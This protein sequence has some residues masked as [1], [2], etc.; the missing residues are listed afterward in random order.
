M[1]KETPYDLLKED[2]KK[3][4]GKNN[5]ATM[6]LYNAL[7]RK[8]YERVSMCKT[9][10]EVWHTL[11]ITHQAKVTAIEEAKDL[12]TLPLDELVRNL[13]LSKLKLREQTSDD[14][15][16][17]RGS[18]EDLDEE[19]AD[20]FNLVARNFC[21]LFRKSNRFGRGNRFGN[22]ANRFGRSRRNSFRNKG[23][24]SSRQKGVCYNCNIK[25]HYASE[26]T[27]PNKNKA[28]VE[29]SWSGSEDGDEPQNDATCLIAI[30][31][32]EGNVVGRG[33][34]SH[35][36]IT[37][38]SVEHASGLTFNLISVGQLYDDDCVVNFTK[39][40]CT[41]INNGKTLVKG[42]RRNGLYTCK[43]GDNSKQQICLASIVDISTL[44]HRRLGYA[45]M[46]LVQNLD[47]NKLVRNLPKLSFKRHFCN[48]CGLRSQGY[49]QTSKAY[50]VLNK[51]TMRIEE[52]L[53]V[54]F[55]ESLPKP[56]SSPLVK[57]DRIIEPIVQNLVRSLPLEA[58]TS[59]S[60]YPKSVK[61]A[62]GYLIEQLLGGAVSRDTYFISGMAMRT[63]VNA[64]DLMS[65]VP[66][67]HDP[68][69]PFFGDL[70][71]WLAS[72]P[73]HLGGL[74]LCVRIF[75]TKEAPVNFLTYPS[76]GRS[77]LRPTDVLFFRWVREK[78]T[79]ADLTGGSPL[80]GLSSRGFSMGQAAL[81]AA[82]CK[83]TKQE[84]ACIEN[85]HVFIPFVFDT[86]G[87]LAP[88]AA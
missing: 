71:W 2:Q 66:Q 24:E 30:D 33:N 6:T 86:F 61:E 45:N 87:F 85:Q 53:N 34:I 39:V 10:K 35:E 80:V 74:G 29:K 40:D 44:W 17:Q 19:E 1:M 69:R 46:R 37:T 48:T 27:K 54:T 7:H 4:L 9:T 59:K 50:I 49:S 16:S 43:L 14:N 47:S 12:A 63:T 26:C 83:V 55:D 20:A 62:R 70:Q 22:G 36:S 31:S 72:L 73:I 8:E 23:G 25:G 81:K 5:E 57:D 58:N 68:Q 51:E 3:Q 41:I 88:E 52:F 65:L 64:V 78:C 84:K 56:K 38:T 11:I 60:G 21:K 15:D 67:L 75:A 82:P 76:D 42:H 28:F 77:T 18:D 79:C 13:K 32:Q